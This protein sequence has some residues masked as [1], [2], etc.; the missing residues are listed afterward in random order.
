LASGGVRGVDDIKRLNDMGI[1]SVIFGKAYYEGILNFRIFEP[2]LV[3]E[4][5]NYLVIYDIRNLE[6]SE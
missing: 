3:R 4:I 5:K 2:V 1:F 6:F